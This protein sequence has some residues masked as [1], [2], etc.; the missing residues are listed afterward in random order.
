MDIEMH[1]NTLSDM[2]EKQG[3]AYQAICPI[4]KSYTVIISIKEVFIN[5]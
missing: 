2:E 1:Q 3:I 5:D 4:S